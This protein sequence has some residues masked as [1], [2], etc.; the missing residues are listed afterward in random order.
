M[1]SRRVNYLADRIGSAVGLT[2]HDFRPISYYYNIVL[3]STHFQTPVRRILQ[4]FS[5]LRFR[6]LLFFIVCF[7]VL[8]ILMSLRF[9]SLPV[10]LSVATTGSA[11]VVMEVLCLIAFQVLYGFVYSRI[12]VIVAAFMVGL[13]CGSL[14]TLRLLERRDCGWRHFWLVQVGVCIYPLVLIGVFRL[15]AESANPSVLPWVEVLFPVLTF[16]AGFVGGLQFP[17]A[18]RF[19]LARRQGVGPA[20]GTVYGVDLFGSCLGAVFASTVLIPILGILDTC[21]LIV[22]VNL[23]SVA[24]IG[25]AWIRSYCTGESS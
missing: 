10:L 18:N 8:A 22:S 2:N 6:S 7:G 25:C 1:S 23:V 13:T 5:S 12:G 21:Y 15:F 20:V 17:L 14:T 3:W 16:L 24:V 11:E 19:Y 4:A 9:K